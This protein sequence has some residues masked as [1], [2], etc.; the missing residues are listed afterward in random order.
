M[1]RWNV[2]LF[3]SCGQ[4]ARD[5]VVQA[6]GSRRQ[7][8]GRQHKKKKGG[9]RDEKTRDERTGDVKREMSGA[10]AQKEDETSS[11]AKRVG[12]SRAE[13]GQSRAEQ[14]REAKAGKA[15]RQGRNNR[16]AAQSW[17]KERSNG[18]RAGNGHLAGTHLHSRSSQR[19]LFFSCARPSRHTMDEGRA[20]G[21]GLDG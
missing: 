4:T 11:G 1:A 10:W 3:P 8:A 19:P 5:D 12:K 17:G 2:V 14:S 20:G 16:Q 15:G 6:A 21:G 7:A 9:M 13:P 18:Q